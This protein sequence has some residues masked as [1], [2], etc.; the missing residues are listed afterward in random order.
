[1]NNLNILLFIRVL[2]FPR[3]VPWKWFIAAQLMSVWK[4]KRCSETLS[5]K[6]AFNELKS[7]TTNL[8]ISTG[9]RAQSKY[10][11]AVTDYL[12]DSTCVQIA[13]CGINS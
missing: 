6:T 10:K 7:L 2:V 9:T 13:L 3:I 8:C 5:W 1:M 11:N 4:G 12:Q